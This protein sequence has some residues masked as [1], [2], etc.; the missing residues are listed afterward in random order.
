MCDIFH[1]VELI[2][3]SE[4]YQKASKPIICLG[5]TQDILKNN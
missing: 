5:I 4:D 3:L 1:T 2:G